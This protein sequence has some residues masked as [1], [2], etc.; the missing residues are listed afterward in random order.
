MS[1]I[2]YRTELSKDGYEKIEAKIQ[3]IEDVAYNGLYTADDRASRFHQ[4]VSE[5]KKLRQVL[6]EVLLIVHESSA[7]GEGDAA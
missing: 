4:I 3:R 7:G 6:R 1:E 2:T 5:V